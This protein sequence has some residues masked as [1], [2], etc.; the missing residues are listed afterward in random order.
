MLLIEYELRE[1]IKDQCMYDSAG[2][3]ALFSGVGQ[4]AVDVPLPNISSRLIP[5]SKNTKHN[6]ASGT[7]F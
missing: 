6:R 4:S 2:F 7:E 1:V 5:C 3:S